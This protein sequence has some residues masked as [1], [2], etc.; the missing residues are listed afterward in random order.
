MQLSFVGK[1][2]AID[3]LTEFWA[4]KRSPID[5]GCVDAVWQPFGAH[6][7]LKGSA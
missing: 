2:A 7:S 4:A 6:F 5:A 3:F 1:A